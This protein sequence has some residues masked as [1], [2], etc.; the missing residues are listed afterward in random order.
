VNAARA[1]LHAD[2]QRIE[3]GFAAAEQHT[4]DAIADRMWDDLFG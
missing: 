4:W 1:A 2:P 3:R